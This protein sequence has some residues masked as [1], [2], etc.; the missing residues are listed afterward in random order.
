[1]MAV[2]AL[3]MGF[4]ILMM[5]AFG[6]GSLEN[7]LLLVSLWYFVLLVFAIFKLPKAA[8]IALVIMG[9]LWV[10]LYSTHICQ[11]WTVIMGGAILGILLWLTYGLLG[12][13][14]TVCIAIGLLSKLKPITR[15]D[16]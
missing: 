13:A 14:L 2:F 10:A 12:I 6:G 7:Y 5:L 8:M 3:A 1:M 4:D 15:P 11:L 9:I 16:A